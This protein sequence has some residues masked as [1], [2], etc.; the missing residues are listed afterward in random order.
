MGSKVIISPQNIVFF[1]LRIC[2]VLANSADPDEMPHNVAIY[3]GLHCLSKYLLR[4][5]L[6]IKVIIKNGMQLRYCKCSKI[7]NTF[8]LCSDK[9]LVSGLDFTKCLSE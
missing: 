8:L 1:S 5:G 4:G 2:F 3:L 6:K 7:S 9:M